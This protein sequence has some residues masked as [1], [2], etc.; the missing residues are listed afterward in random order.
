VP[1]QDRGTEGEATTPVP[2]IGT[3]P[4][5]QSLKD[6]HILAAEGVGEVLG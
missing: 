5:A 3:S 1:P 4:P 2:P 6:E